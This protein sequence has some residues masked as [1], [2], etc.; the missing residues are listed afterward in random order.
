MG[1]V[2]PNARHPGRPKADP[3]SQEDWV[4][5]FIEEKKA[6]PVVRDPGSACGRPE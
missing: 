2:I 1:G 6:I 5:S 3:G 4:R